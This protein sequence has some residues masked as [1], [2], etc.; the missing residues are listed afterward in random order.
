MADAP[1]LSFSSPELTPKYGQ[2]AGVRPQAQPRGSQSGIYSVS[3]VVIPLDNAWGVGTEVI[4]QELLKKSK[5]TTPL[6]LDIR[7][8]EYY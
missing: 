1:L 2:L 5:E 4:F 6:S 3:P 7:K 8:F